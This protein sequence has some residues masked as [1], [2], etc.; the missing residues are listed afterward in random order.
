VIAVADRLTAHLRHQLGV[1]PPPAGVV[2]T[3]SAERSRPGWDGVVRAV[4]GMAAPEGAVL[5]VPAPAVEPLRAAGDSLADVEAAL[6]E[7]FDRPGARLVRSI[8][9]WT[10]EPVALP[11]L[12]EEVDATDPRVPEWLRPFGGEVLVHFDGDG[13][14]VGGVGRKRHDRW[15]TEL[16]VGTEPEARG[17]GVARRLVATAA[18]RVLDE[19]KVPT[20]Q[21]DPENVASAHVADAVG[22]PDTGLRGLWLVW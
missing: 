14:Y 9:R 5:S 13:R 22:F 2:V 10:G 15:C 12:G 4:A 7:V 6:P 17:R 21:H 3:T 20:Y 1:W 16:A 8:L 18:R 11:S 19:G